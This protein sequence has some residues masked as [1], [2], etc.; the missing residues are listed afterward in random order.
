MMKM[1]LNEVIAIY[2]AISMLATYIFMSGCATDDIGDRDHR[3]FLKWSVMREELTITNIILCLLGGFMPIL[4]IMG[5]I[6]YTIA[7]IAFMINHGNISK[8]KPF[9]KRNRIEVQR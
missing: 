2:V 3:L 4:N 6:F 8:I 7:R 1:T 9:R 5:V